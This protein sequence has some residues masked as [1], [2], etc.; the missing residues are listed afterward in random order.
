MRVD[1]F[2]PDCQ[3]QTNAAQFGLCDDENGT[4]AYVDTTPSARWV[5]TVHNAKQQTVTFTAIDQCVSLLQADNNMSS[6]CDAMLTYDKHIDFIE[7]KNQRTQWIA[8]AVAQLSSTISEFFTHYDQQDFQ[9][10]RAFACNRKHR[11]FQYSHRDLMQR[12]YHQHGVRLLIQAD[13]TLS[14]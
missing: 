13:I 5:A 4:V 2:N 10:K 7:L 11:P 3:Q 6:R 8:K 9:Q 1:F 12:F 14:D